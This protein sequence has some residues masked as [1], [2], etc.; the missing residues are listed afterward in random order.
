MLK[1]GRI[2]FA[3]LLLLFGMLTACQ[4]SL[5]GVSFADS[6]EIMV[7][8]RQPEGKGLRKVL[9]SELGEERQLRIT[10]PGENPGDSTTHVIKWREVDNGGIVCSYGTL[11]CYSP[12]A[13]F[14]SMPGT[15][16]LVAPTWMTWPLVFGNVTEDE[17][18]RP[19]DTALLKER[20]GIELDLK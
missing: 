1:K 15:M 2:W 20:Y 18:L 7:T 10:Q 3:I 17:I 5:Q 11:C 6:G 19:E 4:G 16:D 9:G 13:E 12:E 14:S 8:F